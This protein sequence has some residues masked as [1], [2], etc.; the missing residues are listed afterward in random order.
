LHQQQE[1]KYPKNNVLLIAATDVQA[2]M[3]ANKYILE[4]P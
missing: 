3:N 2:A 1:T 4:K